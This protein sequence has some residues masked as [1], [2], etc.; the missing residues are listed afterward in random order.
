[1]TRVNGRRRGGALAATT[2]LVPFLAAT[3][4]LAIWLGLQALDAAR[5]HRE[6]AENA[7]RDYARM[8]AWQYGGLADDR[9]HDAL[10]DVF[11]EVRWSRRRGPQPTP[12]DVLSDLARGL[13]RLSCEC[14]RLRS[15][16]YRFH[17]AADGSD[18]VALPDT[19]PA[20][21][22]AALAD[23]VLSF[24]AS[25]ARHRF[26]LLPLPAGRALGE[27]ASV[28]YTIFRD[29]DDVQRVAGVV[30]P[31]TALADLFGD[32]FKRADLLPTSI[33]ADAPNDSLLHVTVYTVAGDVAFSSAV[34]YPDAYAARDTLDHEFGP[35]IVAAAVRPDAPARLIIGGL[36]SSRLPLIL[37]LLLLTLGV[38]AAALMQ[39]GRERQLARLRDDFISGVSHE[40]RT[41]LAQIRMFAELYES[42]RLRTN[43]ERA[44]AIGVIHRESRRLTHLVDNILRFARIRRTWDTGMVR[45]EIDVETAFHELVEGFRPLAASRRMVLALRVEPGLAVVANPDALN[46]MLTNLVDNAVKYGPAGQRIEMTVARAGGV[47]VITVDDEGPGVPPAERE[48][49]WEAYFRMDRERDSR[50]PGTGIGLAVVRELVKMH[51]GSVR[52]EDAPGG[53]ARFVIELPAVPARE[54][55]PVDQEVAV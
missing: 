13:R 24:H 20:G 43:D 48:R 53:G 52:I 3:L 28:L 21:M 23:T 26:A 54:R 4:G 41:P 36:P 35:L 44:R 22:L 40:L 27:P 42:G 32:W 51:D 1:M 34:S 17:A 8:A 45:E 37:G 29:G 5:S 19:V 10:E 12:A 55:S 14:P 7:L 38:G 15:A 2:W 18:A 30:V 31:T 25:L 50:S 49:V 46:Q 16:S 11:D 9:L 39:I 6:T 33:T 47:A